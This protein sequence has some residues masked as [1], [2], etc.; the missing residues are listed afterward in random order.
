VKRFKNILYLAEPSLD[1]TAALARAVSLAENNQARLTLL[2]VSEPS[3]AGILVESGTLEA[4]YAE[5][6]QYMAARR[7]RIARNA[8]GMSTRLNS[9]R[10]PSR[11]TNPT[12]K[13]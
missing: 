6:R 8:A 10:Y 13:T 5:A 11:P 2:Q 4:R 3:R 12:L 9:H 7:L 1:Q